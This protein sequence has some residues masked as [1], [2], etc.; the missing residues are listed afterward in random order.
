MTPTASTYTDT[1]LIQGEKTVQTGERG[2][3]QSLSLEE[4]KEEKRKQNR[5]LSLSLSLSRPP[6]SL[7]PKFF[8]GAIHELLYLFAS[9]LSLY[10][11]DFW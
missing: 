6:L 4:N 9:S 8:F 11:S 2:T 10:I 3:S 7:T 5:G 1:R